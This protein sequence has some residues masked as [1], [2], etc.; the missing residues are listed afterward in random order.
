MPALA[1]ARMTFA[2]GIRQPVVW[3]AAGLGLAMLLLSLV[4]GMFTFDSQDRLRLLLT[5]GVAVVLLV[6][7]LLAVLVASAAVHDEFAS[8]TAHTLLVKPIS[9]GGCLLGRA[10]GAWATA[11]GVGLLL[12]LTH[13]GLVA[14][15]GMHGFELLDTQHQHHG[16]DHG[17][18]LTI[19]WLRLLAADG[20]AIAHT[21]IVACLATTLALRVGPVINVLICFSAFVLAHLV[22]GI[23][24]GAWL[25][26]ILPALPLFV[27]DESLQFRD[28]LLSPSYFLLC[29]LYALV[30]S[31]GSLL[32]GT[33]MLKRQDLT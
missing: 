20:L 5:A 25:S 33:V 7:L 15:V 24:W 29:V 26:G 17:P 22:A 10:L 32:I 31:A 4:F 6:S 14:L 13:L 16:H 3:L 21:A 1:I 12:I 11:G 19:P 2:N 28:L 23:G 27:I 18:G 8:R 9:R 30:Y